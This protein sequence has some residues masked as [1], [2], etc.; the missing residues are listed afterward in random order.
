MALVFTTLKIN[1]NESSLNLKNLSELQQIK[2]TL[3][4]K[5]HKFYSIREM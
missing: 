2:E 1:V 5:Q 4:G 3:R